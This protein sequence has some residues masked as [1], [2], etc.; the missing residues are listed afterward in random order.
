MRTERQRVQVRG[1]MARYVLPVFGDEA[2]SAIT[3]A[4]IA[5]LLRPIWRT[6]PETA[7]RA[8]IRCEAIFAWAKA[9]GWREGDNP[10][11]W[12][13]NLKPLLGRQRPSRERRSH[14]KAL[15]WRDVPGFMRRLEAETST[16]ALALR[17]A[18]LTAARTGEVLGATWAEVDMQA[19]GGPVW[20]VPADRMKMGVEH[21]VPLSPG[22]WAVLDA[23]RALRRE[24][25]PGG[26]FL[27]PG[28]AGSRGGRVAGGRAGAIPGGLSQ[29]ALLTLLR[30]MGVAGTCTTHGFRSA[31]RT[32]AAECTA[33]P[34]AVAEKALAH[35][36]GDETSQAYDRGDLLEKRRHLMNQW[37]DYCAKALAAM[38][39]LRP[40]AD[41]ANA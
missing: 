15:H 17:W 31:F 20:I 38:V 24:D 14:H 19:P 18:I 1:L 21:R 34:Y 32:W 33:T 27:F 7:L 12:N 22:A 3:P 26:G 40:A 23:A 8:R 4:T 5:D 9:K 39:A 36:V 29:M 13:D 10:A 25:A 16:S 2:V 11:A 28:A 6:K 35:A 30:R 41:A 37:S